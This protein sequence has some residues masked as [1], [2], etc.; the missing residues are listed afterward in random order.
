MAFSK[1]RIVLGVVF[2][3]M[4]ATGGYVFLARDKSPF[5]K[6]LTGDN[7]GL[8]VEDVIARMMQT[9]STSA[10][11][12]GFTVELETSKP[13]PPSLEREIP[14]TPDLDAQGRTV[15]VSRINDTV[16]ALKKDPKAYAS[17]VE[18]GQLRLI[19]KDYEGAREAWNFAAVL[20]P[21]TVT[22]FHNLGDLHM[23]YLKDYPTAEENFKKAM[24]NDIKNPMHYRSLFDLY[25]LWKPNSS[26]PVSI[27]KTGIEKFPDALDLHV[28]LAR[29]YRDTGKIPE[30]RAAYDAAIFV[31]TKAGNAEASAQLK[32]ERGAVK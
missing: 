1:F 28:L 18:L 20:G 15:V 32:A 5:S 19:V 14:A 21:H 7:A 17:W 16:T 12:D 4:C 13:Q 23:N 6:S 26:E 8:S 10:R 2:V 22:P 24:A 11:G 9:G 27:L 31:A 3:L 25:L 29:H 30:A